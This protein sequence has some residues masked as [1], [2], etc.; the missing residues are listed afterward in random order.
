MST[1]RSRCLGGRP[2][3]RSSTAVW[4]GCPI[5]ASCANVGFC[6]FLVRT[7]TA[8]WF[9]VPHVCVFCKLGVFSVLAFLAFSRSP[10][11]PCHPRPE[12]GKEI[13]SPLVAY[14]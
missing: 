1:D 7:A 5:F 14:L 12:M 10:F 9:W 13:K 3:G 11:L 4:F 8:V 6:P 2:T